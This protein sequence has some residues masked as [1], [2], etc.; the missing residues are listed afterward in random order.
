MRPVPE[1]IAELPEPRQGG[2]VD[3]GFGEGHERGLR[4]EPPRSHQ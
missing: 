3:D 4:I 2:G 1:R